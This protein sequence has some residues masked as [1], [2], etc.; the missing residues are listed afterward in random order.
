MVAKEQEKELQ[1]NGAVVQ[2][3]KY[4]HGIGDFNTPIRHLIGGAFGVGM[5]NRII[6]GYTLATLS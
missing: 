3:A 5:I 4:L 6:R 2:V 1:E